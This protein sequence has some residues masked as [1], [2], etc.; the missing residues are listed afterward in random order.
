M[1]EFLRIKK[2]AGESVFDWLV[3][4]WVFEREVPGYASVRG[5]ARVMAAADGEARY[6]ETAIVSLAQGGTRMRATQCY[7]FRRLAGPV[8]GIEVRF[9]D[10]GELFERLEFRERA[11]GGLEARARFLCA[12]D[13]YE[14]AFVVGP[15]EDGEERLRVEHVVRGPRKDYTVRTTYARSASSAA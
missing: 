4:E 1:R 7:W 8:N 2:A 5:E 11:D 9:C 13:V 3:G 12:D 15:V 10:T 6:E 14:S